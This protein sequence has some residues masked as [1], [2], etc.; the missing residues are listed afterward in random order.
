M[1]VNVVPGE[2]AAFHVARYCSRTTV[3]GAGLTPFSANS[4]FFFHMAKNPD[5]N[6]GTAVATSPVSDVV[7]TPGP[8]PFVSW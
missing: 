7:L 2:C 3:S 5:R 6:A 4:A 1:N 8:P